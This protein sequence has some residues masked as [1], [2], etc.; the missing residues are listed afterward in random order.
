[1]HSIH[2]YVY[3]YEFHIFM[4]HTHKKINCIRVHESAHARQAGMNTCMCMYINVYRVAT[5]HR[6]P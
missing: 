6:M 3:I 5:T 4:H 1:M 2:T